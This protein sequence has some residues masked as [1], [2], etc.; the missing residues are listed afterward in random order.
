MGN[1][2]E[3]RTAA[4]V[5]KRGNATSPAKGQPD[6]TPQRQTE[7][8]K[9]VPNKGRNWLLV[10]AISLFIISCFL[11]FA[12][13]AGKTEQSDTGIATNE[14][15]DPI[16]RLLELG[17]VQNNQVLS[18]N[19]FLD[20]DP[21]ISNPKNGVFS[22]YSGGG[23]SDIGLTRDNDNKLVL[24]TPGSISILAGKL[25][26][27]DSLKNHKLGNKAINSL[28]HIIYPDFPD[29][30]QDESLD[31]NTSVAKIVYD[32]IDKAN[33]IPGF[34]AAT[35]ENGKISIKRREDIKIDKIDY[36]KLRA[37]LDEITAQLNG[38]S[39]NNK[40]INA[41]KL[42]DDAIGV[43]QP[44]PPKI[45]QASFGHDT[46]YVDKNPY[47]FISNKTTFF[48]N[49]FGISEE[50]GKNNL[51]KIAAKLG[52]KVYNEPEH[53]DNPRSGAEILFQY[54]LHQL[55]DRPGVYF[56]N[57]NWLFRIGDTARDTFY[58]KITIEPIS[59][60]KSYIQHNLDGKRTSIWVMI[61]FLCF[62]FS[63]LS[64]LAW[65][66]Q[67]N[68]NNETSLRFS[69][70]E[71]IKRW[72]R[73]PK[74][75]ENDPNKEPDDKYKIDFYQK[76]IN[77]ENESKLIELLDEE[78]K[79]S[80]AIP[81]IRTTKEIFHS[82][83]KTNYKSDKEKIDILLGILEEERK[84]NKAIPE[85]NDLDTVFSGLEEI[86]T[87]AG[88]EKLGKLITFYDE[89]VETKKSSGSLGETLKSIKDQ[90]SQ[91][92][93]DEIRKIKT[94]LNDAINDE[95]DKVF[96]YLL[97]EVKKIEENQDIEKVIEFASRF[98]SGQN[99]GLNDKILLDNYK[100][101]RG[102]EENAKKYL[103]KLNAI[104]RLFVAE[105]KPDEIDNYLS[106]LLNNIDKEKE[107]EKIKF[108]ISFSALFKNKKG[109]TLDG[110]WLTTQYDNL[111]KDKAS[112]KEKAESYE[113]NFDAIGSLFVADLKPED[114]YSHL[115][116]QLNNI[117]SGNE[118]EQIKFS[119]NFTASFKNKQGKRIDGQ[120]LSIYYNKLEGD[121]TEFENKLKALGGDLNKIGSLFVNAVSP[122]NI[123]S[124]LEAQLSNIGKGDQNTKLISAIEL[125]AFFK[126]SSGK[127]VDKTEL[128]GYY[129]RLDFERSDFGAQASKYQ[130]SLDNIGTLFSENVQAD[131]V[132]EH[133]RRKITKVEDDQQVDNVI[134]LA[135]AFDSKRGKP[136]D[137]LKLWDDS[138]K[139]NVA[140]GEYL[141][142][143][144]KTRFFANPADG[145][146]KPNLL[147]K[148]AML[149]LSL[150]LGQQL[151]KIR[152]P[153]IV[154]FQREILNEDTNELPMAYFTNYIVK[155]AQNGWQNPQVI[156]ELNV[157]IK[158]YNEKIGAGL[159][160][161]TN[162][163]HLESLRLLAQK[164]GRLDRTEDFFGRM[165][166]YFISDFVAKINNLRFG[167]YDLDDADF[168]WLYE[169]L[170]NITFHTVD[171]AEF[172]LNGGEPGQ[173]ENYTFLLNNLDISSTPHSQFVE[174]SM[175]QS[176]NLSNIVAKGARTGVTNLKLILDRFFIK[177]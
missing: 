131:E 53:P 37:S 104:A 156:N 177:P 58:G 74:K 22:Y 151:V 142:N 76:I 90:E 132:Y 155:T 126:N 60:A 59:T 4:N 8:N 14:T 64:L 118:K 152:E 20:V 161:A 102:E 125:A 73:K 122:E 52:I 149:F 72:R 162:N 86:K 144:Q 7:N 150:N 68:Y 6:L 65:V 15:K 43:N 19:P 71:G 112:F 175:S 46:L 17:H 158:D 30:I 174:N 57:N 165:N 120:Q 16:S 35:I 25:S 36:T 77:S 26:I 55:H 103:E 146:I 106:D 21:F 66:R 98:R 1:K 157:L 12:P 159:F 2:N 148:M 135:A 172:F 10:M 116:T 11:L 138:H 31:L 115:V 81:K 82:F 54:L 51:N 141:T 153:E 27:P 87:C 134:E 108:A 133:L 32:I 50:I 39:K 117:G 164:I 127:Q 109:Q 119:V 13:P 47:P 169:N 176:S 168:A 173:Y 121:K 29:K 129:K 110:A 62:G 114:V 49:E 128:L 79:K 166:K 139:V 111:R 42:I 78:R 95:P 38:T 88:E 97:S 45:V 9:I 101:L 40:E 107:K 124:S 163:I 89:K 100:N 84:Y 67:R 5:Q 83:G 94:L 99:S 96:D 91:K 140:I 105:I 137:V 75:E 136:L 28:A 147:D 48:K 113:K 130:A 34:I 24:K 92:G 33:A 80:T 123:Y 41:S 61:D 70:H 171:Y 167:R 160:P 154:N 93:R 23:T 56:I 18:N 145:S 143:I 44:I 3:V 170:F 63:V 69:F 85:I